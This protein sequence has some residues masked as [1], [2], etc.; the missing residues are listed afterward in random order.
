MCAPVHRHLAE[1]DGANATAVGSVGLD[2]ITLRLPIV[3][4]QQL[5]INA[6]ISHD[7]IP[8]SD[9]HDGKKK[10]TR[11]NC[12]MQLISAYKASPADVMTQAVLVGI[13]RPVLEELQ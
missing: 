10:I 13:E 1:D 6:T 8:V 5:I 12:E 2:A 9:Q 11:M 3:E 4:P 7:E